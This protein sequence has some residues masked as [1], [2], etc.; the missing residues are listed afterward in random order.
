V[1]ERSGT[2]GERITES[3]EG[4]SGSDEEGEADEADAN[5]R[6]DFNEQGTAS[7]CR[8]PGRREESAPEEPSRK[9]EAEGEAGLAGAL[10]AAGASI[11]SGGDPEQPNEGSDSEAHC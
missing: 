11:E 10:A 4:R 3:R 9:L 2:E 8:K 7:N 1:P 5:S 6:V